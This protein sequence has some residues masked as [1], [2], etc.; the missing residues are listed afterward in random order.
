MPQVPAKP[1]NTKAEIRERKEEAA[2]EPVP[3]AQRRFFG[4][5]IWT[6]A[7]A[8]LLLAASAIRLYDLSAKV[9]HHD[10]GVNGVFT[11]TLFHQGGY[12]YN[13]ENFHGPSLYYAALLTTS[14][15]SFFQGR[16]GLSLFTIRLVPALF[17]IGVVWLLLCLRRY[18]GTFGALAAATLAALSPGMVF[19]SRYFI[20]EIM[21]VFFTLGIIVAW[22]KYRETGQP[23]YFI[24]AAA[25]A[26]LLGTTKETWIITVA[27]WMLAVP[28][29]LAF[30]TLFGSYAD[31]A[32]KKKSKKTKLGQPEASAFPAWSNQRLYATAAGV[33][34]GT[35]VLLY[36]SFFMNFP[37]G[38]LD[39]VL[40]F[41][42][43]FA[44]SQ[45][46]DH[47][48]PWSTYLT[49]MW[50]EEAPI[51]ILGALGTLVALA[52]A[53]SR[54]MVFTSFWAMGILA[55]Y[56]LVPY[57]TPWL[58]LS[59]LLPLIILAGYGLGQAAQ[60]WPRLAAVGLLLAACAVSGYQAVDLA[61]VGYDNDTHPYVYAHTNRDFLVL[62][63]DVESIAAHSGDGKQLGITIMAPEHWP[64]PWYLRDYPKAGYW[65]KVVDTQEPVIIA[66]DSQL[67]EVNRRFGERYR[68]IGSHYLRGNKLI[69]Y[70]RKD[71]QP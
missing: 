55:A 16:E 22:L 30:Y 70:L 46:H 60:G 9:M 17:G 20:H 25:S 64:L 48:H 5:T 56:S 27:V 29:M 1:G 32:D 44:T 39:S 28:C 57:K 59:I 68:I 31:E 45:H 41:K 62:V 11:A 26:A 8:A 66:Y 10:E 43:W 33:F 14:V 23:R 37:Q 19:F 18:L 21:F 61:F 49:W 3:F 50:K 58:D 6:W 13:P 40:T 24:L 69:L 35:W 65:G 54:F 63:D 71:L 38:V 4:L 36:S 42:T 7:C 67:D 47:M 53:A 51:L 52:K 34:A 12:K 15:A 2:V